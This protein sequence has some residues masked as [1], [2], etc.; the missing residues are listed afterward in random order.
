MRKKIVAG[1]WKMNKTMNEGLSLIDECLKL[2]SN[3]NADQEQVPAY[4]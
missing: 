1:N 4:Q 3:I 2:T